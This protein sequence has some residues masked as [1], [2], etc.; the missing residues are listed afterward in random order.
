MF[1]KIK[2]WYKAQSDTTKGLLWLS[3]FLIIGIILRWNYI[4]QRIADGF[5]YYS[6]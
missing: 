1:R 2:E 6:R 3:L 4:I 5:H